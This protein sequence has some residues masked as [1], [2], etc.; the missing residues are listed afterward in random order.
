MFM[1]IVVATAAFILGACINHHFD[2]KKID[3]LKKNHMV[4]LSDNFNETF[5]A[6]WGAGFDQGR[7]AGMRAQIL[8]RKHQD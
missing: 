4:D 1:I 6:G 2:V 8:N 7:R 5:A 3:R